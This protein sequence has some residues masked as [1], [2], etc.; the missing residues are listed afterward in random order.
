MTPSYIDTL[1]E[2]NPKGAAL[3]KSVKVD[4]I[5]KSISAILTLNTVAHTLGSLG[6]GAQAVIVFGNAWFG[7]FSGVMTLIILIGTEIIPKTIGTVYWRRFAMPVAY[8]VRTINVALLPI[9]WVTEKF[10]AC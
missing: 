9:I 10:H 8:Y 6:A 4:H 7:V 3:L 5:E 1:E 2:D